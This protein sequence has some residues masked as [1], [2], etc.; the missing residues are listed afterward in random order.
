ML[1]NSR[2]ICRQFYVINIGGPTSAD[3]ILSFYFK[4][5]M[6]IIIVEKWSCCEGAEDRV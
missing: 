3:D 6:Q 1:N 4:D 5:F 2:T